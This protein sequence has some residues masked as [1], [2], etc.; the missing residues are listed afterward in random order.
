MPVQPY[1][2][3]S[4][5][6]RPPALLFSIL[7][8]ALPAG[9]QTS[10]PAA[11]AADTELV[12]LSPVE[13]AADK[14][15]HFSLPLDA[16]SRTGSRLNLTL[17]ELPASVSVITQEAIQLR[18]ARTA[19]EAIEAAVG[20]TGQ[21]GVGS[22]PGYSTRG[23]GSN[24]ITVMR[25]GIRQN[26]NSQSAR[27]LDSFLFDRIE[28]LK[29][30]S[31][32]LYGEGAVGGAVNYVTKLPDA[33]QRGELTFS[34]GA[35]DAYRAGLGFGGPLPVDGWGYRF[36]ASVQSNGG[37]VEGSGSVFYGLSGALQ[38]KP[39]TGLTLTFSGVFLK[40]NIESYYG[41][42]V[43]Y[44]SVVNTT[45]PNAAPEVR[46]VNNATDRLVNPRIDRRTVRLNYNNP[47]NFADTENSFWRLIAEAQ[48]G[49]DWSLRNELY[50]AT[51]LLNWR[52]TENYTW[53]PVTQLVD[54]SSFLLI[55]RDD[56]QWGNRTDL[57]R[58]GEIAGR[59]NQLLFGALYDHN[60]Q[61]RNTGNPGVPG[62]PTPASVALL[63]P[64]RSPGPAVRYTKTANIIVETVA[65]YVEDV[66]TLNPGLKLVGGLR[67]EQ[68]DTTRVSLVGAPTFKKRYTPLTGRA[69]AIWSVTPTVNLYASYSQAAQPVSQLVSLNFAQADFSLQKG[70]QW[71]IGAKGTFAGGKLDATLALFDIE[72]NDILTST[73]D[74]VTGQRISQQIGAVASQGAELALAFSP[75]RDWR[76]EFNL[77]PTWTL[78]F[79]DFNEN[80]G[81]GVISRA[82]NRPSGQP[83]FV[84]GLFG[85]RRLG[86]WLFTAGL[87]HVGDIAA[88]NNNSIW[89]DAYTTLDASIGYT[90]GATT[91]TLRGRNLTDE[92]Y[93]TNG[94]T[95]RRLAEPRS[96]EF[97]VR[98]TF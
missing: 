50:A 39:S 41:T 63:A 80:L 57:T 94:S 43:I 18:G 65:F 6:S 74:P 77:A 55:Y 31:S 22:I 51:Q 88:N 98:R 70:R 62:S 36:D 15:K 4:V 72:K 14:E 29:G 81:T 95:L 1:L 27:P 2:S 11:T 7:A 83:K 61:I 44:D 9:A 33:V 66:L 21:V 84:A 47:D 34:A 67:W 71:E 92:F 40:D 85:S 64:D 79:K 26:T 23:F 45:I 25:D 37:Y 46:R 30:P 3:I 82:G 53:N 93:A 17:R 90:W 28:V 48:L 86:D 89:R 32:L 58:S 68:I 69:G 20:M 87:R 38:W 56:F 13:V 19:L 75:A 49:G 8:L 54:R 16:A 60:D 35:W 97:S 5:S 42:P 78:E 96:A 91:I 12:E 52:N 10:S 73:L 59:P 24:D 76:L